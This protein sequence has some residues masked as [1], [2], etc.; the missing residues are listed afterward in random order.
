[1]NEH[2]DRDEEVFGLLDRDDA[3]RDAVGDGLGDAILRRAEHLHGLLGVLDRH[4]VEQDRVGLDEQVRRDDGEQSGEAVLIVDERIG[5]SGLGRAAART[6]QQVDMRDLIA[7]ADERFADQQL[8]RGGAG[9][10]LRKQGAQNLVQYRG[11][12]RFPFGLVR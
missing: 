2:A 11:H 6:H 5:E 3:F 7:L 8:R 10:G 9:A 12:I 4:L 1:M